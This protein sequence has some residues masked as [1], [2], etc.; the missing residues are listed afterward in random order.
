MNFHWASVSC[1]RVTT[2]VLPGSTPRRGQNPATDHNVTQALVVAGG[3]V[4]AHATDGLHFLDAATGTPQTKFPV[5]SDG[6]SKSL[7]EHAGTIYT[8]V[9][10]GSS[11]GSTLYAVDARS[12]QQRWKLRTDRAVRST[13]V[14]S[15]KAV[16]FSSGNGGPS[17]LHAVD[18]SSGRQLWT[19]TLDGGFWHSAPVVS[20]E[21]AFVCAGEKS[22]KSTLIALKAR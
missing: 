8:A 1:L 20:E 5:G 13:M 18:P 6:L 9:S 22:G 3:L 14:P 16:Y 19:A 2:N 12:G 15:D 21:V 4:Y 17:V 10:D 11:Y 7:S